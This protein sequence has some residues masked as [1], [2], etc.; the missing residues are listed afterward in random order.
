MEEYRPNCSQHECT[1]KQIQ[2]LR[3]DNEKMQKEL[4]EIKQTLKGVSDVQNVIVERYNK[5]NKKSVWRKLYDFFRGGN[6]NGGD[7]I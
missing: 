1:L 3:S 5:Y 6:F 2:D 4:E 7:S